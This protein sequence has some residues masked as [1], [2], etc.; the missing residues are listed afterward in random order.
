MQL[1]GT[2]IR[3]ERSLSRRLLHKS[4]AQSMSGDGGKAKWR[5]IESNPDVLTSLIHKVE[6]A[7]FECRSTAT[8]KHVIIFGLRHKRAMSL[9]AELVASE[10]E[11]NSSNHD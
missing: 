4:C 6:S 8:C 11:D 7:V 1:E 10:I 3:S 5:A 2:E 9:I